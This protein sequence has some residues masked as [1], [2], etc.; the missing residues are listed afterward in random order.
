MPRSAAVHDG[1][2]LRNMRDRIDAL[3]GRL[4]ITAS[5]GRLAM[6]AVPVA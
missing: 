4:E 2:G 3:H 6:V 1:V 5:P